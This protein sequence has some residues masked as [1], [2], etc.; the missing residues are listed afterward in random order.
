MA[1][2]VTERIEKEQALLEILD[3]YS[4][5]FSLTDDVMFS[6]DHKVRVN[7]VSPN[8]RRSLDTNLKTYRR[9]R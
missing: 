7:S 1:R 9:T 3:R 6:F 8:E 5:H 2:D 4:T